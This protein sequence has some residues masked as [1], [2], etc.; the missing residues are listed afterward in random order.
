MPVEGFSVETEG[1]NDHVVVTLT[2]DIDLAAADALWEVLD[3]NLTP[4]G[5]LVVSCPAIA[6]L[7]SM[8]L[9]ALIRAHHKAAE[10]GAVF[11][12]SEP[13]ATVLRVLELAGIP[14]LFTIES[15]QGRPRPGA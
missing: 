1:A 3:Q 8:G 2:G 5:T 9:G 6:F 13:S 14:D 11:R 12:L 10:L 15:G 7:D 4:H